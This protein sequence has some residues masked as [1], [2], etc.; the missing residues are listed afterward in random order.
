MEHVDAHRYCMSHVWLLF[1]VV[2]R[3][4]LPDELVSTALCALQP[5]DFLTTACVCNLWRRLCM[6]PSKD[7]L[8]WK[9]HA[10]RIMPFLDIT[11]FK[12]LSPWMYSYRLFHRQIAQERLP[13]LR[14]EL[15]ETNRL[16]S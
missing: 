10:L 14:C 12:R 13:Q 8:Y 15:Q 3:W 4:Q 16:F 1:A 7:V 11:L 5:T 2:A 6:E 9:I